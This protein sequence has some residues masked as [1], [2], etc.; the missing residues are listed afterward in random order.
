MTVNNN[1]DYFSSIWKRKL[2]ED[3]AQEYILGTNMR[4]DKALKLLGSGTRFLD[5]GCGSGTLLTQLHNRFE[6]VRGVDVSIEAVE[7]ARRRGLLVDVIDLNSEALAFPDGYFQVVTI[8]STLQYFVDPN[9][10]LREINR[11]L[12]PAGLLL[13]SVPNMRALWRVARLLFCGSFPRV[14]LDSEGYDGGTLHYFALANLIELLKANGFVMMSS[15]GI[16]CLPR[17]IERLPN[18]PPLRV[19]KREFFSAEIFGYAR[20]SS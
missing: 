1:G 14:S 8:L 11:V 12:L 6:E 3:P 4:V 2:E 9:R 5:I 15:E 17:F 20:K 16:F 10:V 7:A 19:L 18:I 13:V